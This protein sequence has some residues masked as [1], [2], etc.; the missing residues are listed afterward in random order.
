MTN[1]QPSSSHQVGHAAQEE[2]V[3]RW[4]LILGKEE[5]DPGDDGDGQGNGAGG[6][7]D[8]VSLSEQ[9]R[10][11]DDVLEMLYGDEGSLDDSAPD[12]ARRLGD[13]HTYFSTPVAHMMQRDALKRIKLQRLLS[14]P[15]LLA[16]IEPNL[17]L[18]TKLLALNK[19]MPAQTRETARQVVRQVVEDLRDR[20]E[21]PLR[22][23]ISGS[24]NRALRARQ[25]RQQKDINWIQT[26][27]AN[28]K[29]Y[30]V[31]Q[32]TVVPETLVGYGRQRSSLRDVIL[33]ID[34]SGSMGQSVVYAS[35]FGAVL[36][37]LPAVNIRLVVFDSTVVDLTEKLQD[38]VDLLFGIQLRGGTNID[39][40][41]AYCQQW[42]KRPQE[43]ILVLISDLYE[44]GDRAGMI[45][46]TAALVTGGVQ[47][48]VLLAL[49]D[50]GAP[51]F[52]RGLAQELVNIGV[53]S[54]ACTPDLF[55]ELMSA[56]INKQ[57]IRQ[58]AARNN[59]VTAPSN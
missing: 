32:R 54:F 7:E 20:L 1:N 55:P 5:A 43:T 8:Q 28:L 35:I 56:A 23:A 24:L 9:D 6:Q 3:R 59:V 2:R 40:A 50:H 37:S 31:E 36:A 53:P 18:V 19:V 42:V 12:I 11:I 10:G 34:Q 33:C 49:N 30:Q 57:D 48:I 4:R 21:Y 39:R 46:R 44:G 15:E 17:D 27:R 52:N 22:Q 25:P 16:E 26:I 47:V 51:R 14:E 38:P 41:L 45:R 58:W 13:I 29:H